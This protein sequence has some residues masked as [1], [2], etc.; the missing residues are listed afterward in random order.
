[1]S[2]M[3]S[4][5]ASEQTGSD[6][7]TY[8]AR[9][10]ISISGTLYWFVTRDF[11]V[12]NIPQQAVVIAQLI[13][14]TDHGVTGPPTPPGTA[15]PYASPMFSG[16][17]GPHTFNSPKLRPVR[18]GLHRSDCGQILVR[19]SMQPAMTASTTPAH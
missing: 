18:Q 1:M 17:P 3:S 8:K 16:T 15:Q 11:F 7:A 6:G 19:M 12:P 2:K 5:C 13:K 10:L 14:S 9:G 4:W